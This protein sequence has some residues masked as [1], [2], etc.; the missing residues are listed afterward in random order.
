MLFEPDRHEALCDIAW[1]GARVADAVHTLVRDI[2]GQRL[3]GGS[4][5]LHPLDDEGDEPPGGFKGLYLGSSGVLW[6]LGHLQRR[7]AA[8]G[9]G[10]VAEGLR[11]A[12]AAYLADPDEGA[13]VPSLF[14]GEGGILLAL[15]QAS[16]DGAVADRLHAVVESNID[17]P[18]LETFWGAPGTMLAAWHLWRATAEDRWRRLFLRH[19]DALWQRWDFDAQAGCHLWT[20]QLDGKAVQYLGGAHGFAGNVL[21]LL[22]GASLLGTERRAA[23]YERCVATLAA[24]ARHAGGAVNWPPATGTPRPG[25]PQMLMQ[26]C[27]GAPGIVTALADF[28]QQPPLLLEALLVGA[29][30]AIWQAGP[31]AKGAG[32]C[33]GTA[34]NGSALLQLHRRTGD[35][36]WLDRARAFAMHAIEQQQRERRQH[37]RGRYTLWTGDAGLAVF[38]QQCLDGSAGMPLLDLLQ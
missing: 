37:G 6:A 12:H 36:L 32:L 25:R 11:E 8:A 5:S 38:L 13:V 27:H 14:S 20:Q 16:G 1:D 17:H 10:D 7:G 3:A 2:E 26:W 28:P 30:Q 31:L 24:T 9:A 23:L 29:G 15:W 4:W 33:H 35:T 21:P 34:G 22:K 18:A 19:A